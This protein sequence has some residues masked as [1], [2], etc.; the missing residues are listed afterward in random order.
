MVIP[1]LLI[2]LLLSLFALPCQAKR[3]TI[4]TAEMVETLEQH[5]VSVVEQERCGGDFANVAVYYN[6]RNQICISR[7]NARTSQLFKQALA[8]EATHAV[9]DCKAG[10]DN[11]RMV[12]MYRDNFYRQLQIMLPAGSVSRIE[13]LYPQEDWGIEI[14][15]YVFQRMPWVIN[16][17]VKAHC[18]RR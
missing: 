16:E 5:G 4:T 2:P 6:V 18:P 14:E 12:H 7:V 9:Q 13:S 8:H 17:L 15:A 10:Q 11:G 3:P 1:K